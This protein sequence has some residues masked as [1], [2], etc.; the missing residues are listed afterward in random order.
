MIWTIA[1]IATIVGVNML[2]ARYPDQSAYWSLIVGLVFVLR[3]LAQRAIGHYVLAAMA[4]A[5][6]ATWY[7]ASP[8]VAIAS[9]SAFAAAELIDWAVYSLSRR[10]LQDR[11][12]ISSAAS[13]PVDSL[14]FLGIVGILTPQLFALQ[15]VAKMIG[16]TG[17]WFFLKW[18]VA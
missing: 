13:V 15:A 9:V 8:F 7:M 3:D 18:R 4:V 11:I 5:G 10:P 12:L 1:Y 17:V 16:A 14:I 2:F 6:L